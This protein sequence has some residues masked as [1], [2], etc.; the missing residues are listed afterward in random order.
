MVQGPARWERRAGGQ[1]NCGKCAGEKPGAAG[2][3][4]ERRHCWSKLQQPAAADFQT[5][6]T[7]RR[8][9]A[10]GRLPS[11]SRKSA[12]QGEGASQPLSAVD[13]M[14]E[15]LG[16]ARCLRQRSMAVQNTPTCSTWSGVSTHTG[17]TAAGQGE[18]RQLGC[19]GEQKA[20]LGARHRPYPL[21]PAAAA[22]ALALAA[23]A[24]TSRRSSP[25][26]RYPATLLPMQ[27][28][29]TNW[30]TRDGDV[31]AFGAGP[32]LHAFGVH[33]AD[34][35]LHARRHGSHKVL[36]SVG[37]REDGVGSMSSM[38][39]GEGAA[40]RAAGRAAWAAG[41]GRHGRHGRQHGQQH[42]RRL[43][44]MA[45]HDGALLR[46]P[47]W[48]PVPMALNVRWPGYSLT[49]GQGMDGRADVAGP[50]CN[51]CL[52]NAHSSRCRGA[53]RRALLL[54]QAPSHC[55][56]PARGAAASNLLQVAHA[57]AGQ[58]SC[59]TA[60]SMKRSSMTWGG[61]PVAK[62][63]ARARLQ[64]ELPPL[65]LVARGVQ[66][67]I[68]AAARPP[69]VAAGGCSAHAGGPA[70]RSAASPRHRQRRHERRRRRRRRRTGRRCH[71]R[72]HL[73]A[74][75]AARLLP[76]FWGAAA[77]GQSPCRRRPSPVL[78]RRCPA[79]RCRW[80]IARGPLP[81]PAER[82]CWSGPASAPLPATALAA[83]RCDLPS[84]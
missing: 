61:R 74:C 38:G 51:L 26:S 43:R 10:G 73:R 36:R 59:S 77:A 13:A 84:G 34:D 28:G 41:R 37:S 60:A 1:E 68:V 20:Q 40:G 19:G 65:A 15:Q 23:H 56:S 49:C 44:G 5:R 11:Y 30:R 76:W 81:L 3:K 83:C 62:H 7:L 70:S 24:R 71:P 79:R 21:P 46:P 78:P 54:H 75:S 63:Q 69:N 35:A 18:D 80:S 27:S 29:K 58:P 2:R 57:V 31:V 42:G 50:A 64:V 82:A 17:P 52:R 39:S 22:A 8:R 45:H 9:S 25:P 66:D 12:Q 6:F 67:H 33:G 47:T 32:L 72:A 53:C 48:S 14:E 16:H 55:C 4:G